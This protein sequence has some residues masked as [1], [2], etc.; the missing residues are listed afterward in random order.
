MG[1]RSIPSQ[2]CRYSVVAG[3][4]R[5]R[6]EEGSKKGFETVWCRVQGNSLRQR[7]RIRDKGT[8]NRAGGTHGAR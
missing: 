7:E 5:G 2:D 4:V 6:L 3:R 8:L 1:V